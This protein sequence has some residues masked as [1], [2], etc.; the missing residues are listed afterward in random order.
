MWISAGLA[1]TCSRTVPVPQ[2]FS[3]TRRANYLDRPESLL[4]GV[5]Q[6]RGG[7]RVGQVGLYRGCRAAAIADAGDDGCG[8]LCPVVAVGLRGTGIGPVTDRQERAQ[9]R[10]A[11]RRAARA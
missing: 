3:V 8:V 5:E 11:H 10:T 7:G 2:P 9:D 1:A 4:G 6:Q